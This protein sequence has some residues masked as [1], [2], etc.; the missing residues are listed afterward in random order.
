MS[1]TVQMQSRGTPSGSDDISPPLG[2]VGAS[3]VWNGPSTEPSV[4][5]GGLGWLMLSTRR[6]RPRTSERRINSWFEGIASQN[7]G[8]NIEGPRQW[9]P[10]L[11]SMVNLHGE[12]RC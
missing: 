12:H 3:C 1:F 5:E 10:S 4:D 8:R 11:E 6:E 2:M 9:V 7:L